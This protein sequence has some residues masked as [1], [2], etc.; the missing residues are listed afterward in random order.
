[1]ERKNVELTIDKIIVDRL[2]KANL[3]VVNDGTLTVALDSE[4][5]EELKLEGYVRDLVRGIQNLRKETGLAV[6]DRINLVLSGCD[7]LN[8]A[9]TNFAEYISNE[10]LADNIEWAD[11]DNSF[12]AI[13]AD[14]KVWSAKLEKV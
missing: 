1:M 7:E 12:T 6:T 2:E 4:I 14:D 9:F 5:T 11:K 13:E 10:T 8:K 3:E